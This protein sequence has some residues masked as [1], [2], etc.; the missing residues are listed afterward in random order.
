M[1]SGVCPTPQSSWSL[2]LGTRS[3]D[4][5][6]HLRHMHPLTLL[7]PDTSVLGEIVQVSGREHRTLCGI[8]WVY[9]ALCT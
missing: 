9:G 8:G 6:G 7:V 1:V 5:N 2:W 3:N 4:R